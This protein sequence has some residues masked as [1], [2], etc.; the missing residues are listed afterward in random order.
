MN[1]YRCSKCGTTFT[2]TTG[3]IFQDH[4][5]PISGWIDFCPGIFRYQSFNSISKSNRNAYTTTKYWLSKLFLILE[6]YQKDIM[7]GGQVYLDETFIKVRKGDIEYKQGDREY[8]GISRNQMCIGMACD[9]MRTIAICHGPGKT[10]K[11]RTSQCFIS[12][13]KR[14]STLIHDEEKAHD[15]LVKE[16]GL[17]SRCYN[18]RCCRSLS[19]KENPL[20]QINRRCFLLKRFLSSHSGFIRYDIQG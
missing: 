1:R 16:L 15:I 4:K 9:K 8:R 17:E 7:L 11:E 18:A 5:I 10:T 3:T 2:I 12:H 14:G 20:Y 13:I 19:D 6:D